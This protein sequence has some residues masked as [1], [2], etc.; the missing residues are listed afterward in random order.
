MDNERDVP[1]AAEWM[2]HGE[3][4]TTRRGHRIA[5]RRRGAGPSVILL[6]GFPT[7]SFDYAAV[8]A[9]L[10]VDHDVITF[11]FLGYGASDKPARYDY[12]VAEGADTVEDLLA[13]LGVTTA[14]V[15][16]H[17]FGG[18]VGQELVDRQLAGALPFTIGALTLLNTGIIYS[19]YRPTRLQRL[20]A[21]PVV[22][23]V[24]AR[25]ISAA[26]LRRGLAGVWGTT[27]LTDA[28]FRELWQG[29]SRDNGHRLAHRQLR[30]N[31]ERD[32]HHERWAAALAAWPGPLHLVWGLDDPVSGRHVLDRATE[33]LPRA[34][35]TRL[36]GVGHFPQVEAPGAVATA[37]RASARPGAA[38]AER[39]HVVD[40]DA[41]CRGRR[42]RG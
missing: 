5:Y 13:H 9:D 42:G 29:I 37:V 18:I 25:L 23:A 34:R 22:G 31:A 6:H 19:A 14:H 26:M 3:T 33:L 7:W 15:V 17:D 27:K 32:R 1:P 41:T 36:R 2:A 8:A 28:Q 21:R 35:V 10:A 11:D 30:Y 12:S 24:I 38:D 40:A 16:A 4:L 39:V 20:A